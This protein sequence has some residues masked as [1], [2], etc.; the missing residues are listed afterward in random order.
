[1]NC[2]MSPAWKEAQLPLRESTFAF[3]ALV[4]EV[5]ADIQL[6]AEQHSIIIEGRNGCHNPGRPGAH[7]TGSHEFINQRHQI[8]AKLERIFL[9]N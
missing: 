3:D 1:M 4:A 8:R 2:W 9:S 5:V 7:W 6:T